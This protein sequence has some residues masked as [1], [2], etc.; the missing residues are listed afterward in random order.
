MP[1]IIFL[2]RIAIANFP[3]FLY[4]HSSPFH[5]DFILSILCFQAKNT[6]VSALLTLH[7]GISNVDCSVRPVL[8]LRC[9]ISV[10]KRRIAGSL[11][12][13]IAGTKHLAAQSFNEPH[14]C[15][16]QPFSNNC[17][18]FS[19]CCVCISRAF[20]RKMIWSSGYSGGWWHS[21]SS[22]YES[23]WPFTLS[24]IHT[25]KHTCCVQSATVFVNVFFL[26]G[27]YF[28][29]VAGYIP[30]RSNPWTFAFEQDF[31]K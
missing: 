2:S 13:L 24:H 23:P 11:C 25:L 28:W 15:H 8:P 16:P 19:T 22:G 18:H 12:L 17:N 31:E 9:H 1:K 14:A 4:P 3:F 20:L 7:C 21:R 26:S 5:Y 10:S 29:L 30:T 6:F 27:Q